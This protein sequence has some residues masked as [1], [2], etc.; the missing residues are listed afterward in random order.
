MKN[1]SHRYDINR[2]N[3]DTNI[4]NIKYVWYDDGYVQ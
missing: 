1:W 2:T 3:M 4:L